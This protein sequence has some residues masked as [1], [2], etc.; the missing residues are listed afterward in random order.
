MIVARSYASVLR[1]CRNSA[2]KPRNC[3][4]CGR[5]PGLRGAGVSAGGDDELR[6]VVALLELL[7]AQL[8]VR[9]LPGER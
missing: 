9:G 5:D 6:D 2:R 8:Q 4:K 3:G 7:V 1:I